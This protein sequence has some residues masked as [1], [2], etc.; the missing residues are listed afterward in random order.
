MKKIASAAFTLTCAWVAS[1]ALAGIADD[2]NLARRKGCD[3]KPGVTQPLRP[4]TELDVVAR[5]WSKGGRLRDALA[6]SNYRATNSAS[7][8]IAGT[9]DRT[10]I[11]AALVQNYCATIIDAS[12][13]EIGVHQQR[14]AVWV[15]V[16]RPFAAASIRDAARV[17]RRVLALVN[18]A[19]SQPR[20]C[21]SSSFNAAPPL[22]SSA[23][24]NQAAL[25]H[26]QDMLRNNLFQ[27]EGSDGSKVGDRVTRVG[28]QWRRVGE[29]VA[30]GAETPEAVVRGWLDSP[31]HCA[32]IMSPGFTEMG[33]AY[34]VDPKSEAGIY[35]TQV[36]A[37]PR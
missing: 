20:N 21:G 27:H 32:N 8:H 33:V 28:Y 23:V 15:V 37:T 10:A 9:P 4:G 22:K 34:V 36:F 29:N 1:P 11:V 18:Q 30:T 19:R 12:F 26:S 6:R 5:E 35:W 16:A 3:S 24:L 17:S 31:G 14:D 7:M 2:L 13:T 25:I